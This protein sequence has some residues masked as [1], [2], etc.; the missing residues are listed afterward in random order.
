MIVPLPLYFGGIIM[1]LMRLMVMGLM[2]LM[3]MGLMGLM[4][5]ELMLMVL[6][7]LMLMGLML[8]GLCLRAYG[9][10]HGPVHGFRVGLICVR[11]NEFR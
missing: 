1:R 6:V 5:M 7:G 11:G 3:L 2:G 10:T 4:L 9:S 8:R